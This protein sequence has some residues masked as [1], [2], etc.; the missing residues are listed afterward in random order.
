MTV[1][2]EIEAG[3]VR[4]AVEAYLVRPG[5]PRR[6]TVESWNGE[7]ALGGPAETVLKP[8]GFSRVPSG[9]EWYRNR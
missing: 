9:L 6:I 4:R 2:G 5:A 3:I 1:P 7:D 8:L